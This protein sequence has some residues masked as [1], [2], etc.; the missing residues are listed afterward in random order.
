VHITNPAAYAQAAF[1]RQ[2]L[3]ADAALRVDVFR[4]ALSDRLNDGSSGVFRTTNLEP[5]LNVMVLPS[6]RIPVAL[7]ANY[8]RAA[9]SEDARGMAL[10]PNSPR[11]AATDFTMLGASLN[12]QRISAST[13]VFLID[14]Q[15]ESVYDAD[16]GTMEY[17]GPS[18]SYGWEAK[19]SIQ[20]SRK[21]T[22]N[23]GLTQVSNAFFRGTAPREYVDSAP[24]SVANASFTLNGWRGLYSSLSYRHVSHYLVVNP[25]DVPAAPAAPYSFGT[26]AEA[27]GL[28]VLDFAA[29]KK[30]GHGLECNLSIDNLNNKRYYETQNYFN[31]R[32]S[33]TAPVRARL[34]GTPGYPAGV[35]VGLTWRFE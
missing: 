2:H 23:A 5:K 27:S 10:N 6:L 1:D 21:L 25:D 17:Q 13:D 7:H 24:H 4:F 35:E 28:D 8:G 33:P 30:L 15:H 3:H 9:T 22:W 18:R 29:T 14:R 16:N 26:H 31:S 20:L 19:A 32:T 11:T 12:A 34:H